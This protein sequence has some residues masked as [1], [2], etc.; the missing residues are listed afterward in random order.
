MGFLFLAQPPS[1]GLDLNSRCA[2]EEMVTFQVGQPLQNGTPGGFV[3]NE[4]FPAA[5]SCV[6]GLWSWTLETVVTGLGAV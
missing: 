3:Q 1:P 2:S 6:D 5:G 4:C